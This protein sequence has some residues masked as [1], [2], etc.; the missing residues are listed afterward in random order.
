MKI[1]EKK[2][3]DMKRD[4]MSLLKAAW[5]V[6]EGIDD[7]EDSPVA[8]IEFWRVDKLKEELAKWEVWYSP[9]DKEKEEHGK[10]GRAAGGWLRG[11][12]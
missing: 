1:M 3:M 8:V 5:G 2:S 9:L 6:L 4:M 10:K 7:H 11:R 12:V